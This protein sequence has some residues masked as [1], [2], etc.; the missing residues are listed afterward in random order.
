MTKLFILLALAVGLGL[1]FFIGQT[2]VLLS[3][4]IGSNEEI[5][6][7]PDL[8]AE[9]EEEKNES[10]TKT[11][12]VVKTEEYKKDTVTM[13][14]KDTIFENKLFSLRYPSNW[15]HTDSVGIAQYHNDDLVYPHGIYFVSVDAVLNRV[16]S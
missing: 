15:R 12:E 11:T 14:N 8:K 3:P 13:D 4:E 9:I 5:E 10:E 2:G 16:H 6:Q 7:E 1:G